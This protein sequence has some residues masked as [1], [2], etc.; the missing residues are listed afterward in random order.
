[1][2][3]TAYKLI[4][5]ITIII[6]PIVNSKIILTIKYTNPIKS[7]NLSVITSKSHLYFFLLTGV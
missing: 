4:V 7:K 6:I 2:I 5:D 1:M 3:K